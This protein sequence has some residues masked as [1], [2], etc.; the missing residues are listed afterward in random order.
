VTQQ[1]RRP[2]IVIRMLRMF[3]SREA[4]L[5]G[6]VSRKVKGREGARATLVLFEELHE[7]RNC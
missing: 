2:S 3:R 7:H 1:Q 4:C 5:I 6:K